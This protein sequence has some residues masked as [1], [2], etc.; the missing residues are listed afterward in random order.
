[1]AM[2]CRTRGRSVIREWTLLRANREEYHKSQQGSRGDTLFSN[3]DNLTSHTAEVWFDVD[4]YGS[5]TL[6]SNSTT[7][8]VAGLYACALES[9]HDLTRWSAHL[10][11]FGENCQSKL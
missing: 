2:E 11:V 9:G 7:L 5:G 3:W 8:E 6:Y 1:M 4:P 10:I